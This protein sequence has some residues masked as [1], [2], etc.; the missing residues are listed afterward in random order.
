M[1]IQRR[2][3]LLV[4]LVLATLSTPSSL[5]AQP[6]DVAK[7]KSAVAG[8]RRK[9]QI[10][11]TVDKTE[12]PCYV[13]TPE[14]MTDKPTPLLVSLHTWSGGVE[15]RDMAMEEGAIAKGWI[16]LFPHFRGPNQHPDACGSEIA[17][18]DILDAVAWA[19]KE[20]RIDKTRVYLTGVSGGGH[21]TMQMVGR[22][23][24]VWTAASAWVGI[25]DMAQWHEK[26]AETG[27][28]EMLRKSCGG[29][30]GT[31]KEVDGEYKKRSPLTWLHRAKNVPLDIAAGV[32][33]GHSGSVPIR[34]SLSAFNALAKANQSTLITENE[35]AQLSRPKGHLN[36]PLDSDRV[37]DATFG[38]KIYLRRQAGPS[39]VT[40][41]E[42][43]HE[44]IT[45]AAIAW[46]EKHQSE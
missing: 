1:K 22:Y 5:V 16:Y 21:M 9:V 24:E 28:G 4:A 45:A 29:A 44:G 31:S 12:Q 34:H 37:E 27:Y 43:G 6:S 32:H 19:K 13:I 26:H 39:R 2:S 33:D 20:F 17:Q 46:L 18:Q 25:S 15:Q 7:A 10:R 8:I 38:R 35:M 41:F 36:A 30:P 42:G 14:K 11:S 40:I 23:P 3:G